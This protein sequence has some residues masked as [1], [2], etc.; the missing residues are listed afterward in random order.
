M[1]DKKTNRYGYSFVK[2]KIFDVSYFC[3]FFSIIGDR[4]E[5]AD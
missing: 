2:L 1:D 4:I 3:C 5:G